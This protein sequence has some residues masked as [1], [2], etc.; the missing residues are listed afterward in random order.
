MA[1]RGSLSNGTIKGTLSQGGLKLRGRLT[2]S[3]RNVEVYSG[4]YNVT[5]KAWEETVLPTAD[6]L[7]TDD[8]RVFEIPYAEVSNIQG[9]YTVTIGG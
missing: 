4:E 6:K 3:A 7:L 5:P 8:V 1:L 2:T 9:G